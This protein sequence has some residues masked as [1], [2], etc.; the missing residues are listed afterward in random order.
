VRGVDLERLRAELDA[1]LSSALDGSIFEEPE[2]GRTPRELRRVNDIAFSGDGE[3]TTCRVFAESVALADELKQNHGAQ[4]IK[5]ILIT[6]ACYLTR[7][8]VVRG[9]E[10]MDRSNGEIWAKLDAGTEEYHRLINRP[11]YT[12]RHVVENI[13]HAAQRR[14]V[15]IQSLFMRVDGEGPSHDE[16]VAFTD[17]LNEILDGGGTVSL[18][19][20]YTVA[21]RPAQDFVT[22]LSGEDVDAIARLVTDRTKLPVETFYG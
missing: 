14:P 11:N 10:I 15:V 20:V 2:F 16:I 8:E 9:L 4:E 19:Q 13:T 5:L 17:R 7:P 12:L 22:A 3:P 18:V 21:R 1:L 6:D